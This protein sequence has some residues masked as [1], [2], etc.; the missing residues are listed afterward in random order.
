[1]MMAARLEREVPLAD[2]ISHRYAIGQAPEALAAVEAGET[3]KAVI[4]PTL[5]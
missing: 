4:D 5:N 3:V 1:M 2:L